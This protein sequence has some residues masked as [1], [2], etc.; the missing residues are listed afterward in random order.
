MTT[1][2]RIKGS[3]TLLHNI[4]VSKVQYMLN[5][6]NPTRHTM[7][8]IISL[9]I[10]K[11]STMIEDT[12]TELYSHTNMVVLVQYSST[13]EKTHFSSSYSIREDKVARQ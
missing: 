12:T 5:A 10:N 4:S 8:A 11:Y 1:T 3:F 13:A 7:N 6:I 2:A 9:Y